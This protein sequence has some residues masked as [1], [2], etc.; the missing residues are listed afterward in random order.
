MTDLENFPF[1]EVLARSTS[2]RQLVKNVEKELLSMFPEVHGH[3]ERNAVFEIY[4]D[5]AGITLKNTPPPFTYS[6]WC[7]NLTLAHYGHYILKACAYD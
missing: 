3:K 5:I 4:C 7:P 6:F 1:N 2:G